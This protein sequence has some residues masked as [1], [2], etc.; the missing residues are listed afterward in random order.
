MAVI[1]IIAILATLVIVTYR[2]ATVHADNVRRI[3]AAH[4]VQELLVLYAATFHHSPLIDVNGNP[5][6][7][8][9][10]LTYDNVCSNYAGDTVTT[11]N[12]TLMSELSKMGTP[13]QKVNAPAVTKGSGTIYHYG[14]LYFDSY[15]APRTYNGKSAPA[16]MMFWLNGEKQDCGLQDV[17]MDDPNATGGNQFITSTTGYTYSVDNF[18]DDVGITECWVS[19]PISS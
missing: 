14:G 13:P 12:T 16:L 18:S 10:C 5:I 1:V 11:S 3:D 15:Y 7:N 17:V 6:S 8:G 9:F 19:V 2:D 4:Q